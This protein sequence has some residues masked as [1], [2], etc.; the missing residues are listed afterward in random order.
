MKLTSFQNQANGKSRFQEVNVPLSLERQDEF[1]HTLKLSAAYVSPA[2]QFVELPAGMDQ[3]W[4]TAPARQLVVVLS[5]E[6]E[7]ESGDG[8]SRRWRAGE[9]FVPADVSG[10]GHRTRC[11]GGAVRLLFA[12]LPDGFAF[13]GM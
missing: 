13:E 10:Q 8:E 6:I 9:A 4:H 7:V 11:I 1:G 12:P 5:G 2:V 3:D